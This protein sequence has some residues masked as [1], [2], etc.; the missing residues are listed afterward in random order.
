[1]Q[2]VSEWM[3]H[4]VVTMS[5]HACVADAQALM[6]RQDICHLVLTDAGYV[7]GV[8]CA[9]DLRTAS[10]DDPIGRFMVSPVLPILPTQSVADAALLMTEAK[11]GCLPVVAGGNLVGVLSRSDLR[12]AGVLDDG[13]AGCASCGATRHLHR[14]PRGTGVF[15]CIDC[16]FSI[17]SENGVDLGTGD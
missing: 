12:R 6:A 11:I 5:S 10:A 16:L 9:C 14:D 1:M 2:S 15:Y 4:P 3:S 7:V 17:P 13:A 8:V